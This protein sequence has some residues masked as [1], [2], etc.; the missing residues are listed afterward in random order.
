[1]HLS[2]FIQIWNL[3]EKL[4]SGEDTVTNF[5]LHSC[6]SFVKLSAKTC[7]H[8]GFHTAIYCRFFFSS[9]VFILC[10]R[11]NS[12]IEFL[13]RKVCFM[14][15]MGRRNDYC[16][17]QNEHTLWS[18]LFFFILVKVHNC[19][20]RINWIHNHREARAQWGGT[21][22]IEVMNNKLSTLPFCLS[23]TE[24]APESIMLPGNST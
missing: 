11:T 19:G 5:G 13:H 17:L 24:A 9:T 6:R 15:N 14:A 2:Y 10:A 16:N 12:L 7:F 22:V 1:M 18:V 4:R 8:P 21:I 23:P 3:K 20:R